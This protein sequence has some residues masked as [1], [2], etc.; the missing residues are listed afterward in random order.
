MIVLAAAL[1]GILQITSAVPANP[2]IIVLTLIL[3]CLAVGAMLLFFGPERPVEKRKSY[4]YL[5]ALTCI[6]LA[7]GWLIGVLA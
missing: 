4:F 1:I 5:V 3:A 7:G 2:W 6:V